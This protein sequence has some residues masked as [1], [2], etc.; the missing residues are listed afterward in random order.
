MKELKLASI[1]LIFAL[2]ITMPTLLSQVVLA[3]NVTETKKVPQEVT[4]DTQNIKLEQQEFKKATPSGDKRETT[5]KK[6]EPR[7]NIKTKYEAQKLQPIKPEERYNKGK[8]RRDT[9]KEIHRSPTPATEEQPNKATLKR[10]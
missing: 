5:K 3:Q 6:T 2:I 4:K 7:K 9:K 1:G 8:P 10:W